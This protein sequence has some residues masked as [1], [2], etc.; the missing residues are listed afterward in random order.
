[1]RLSLKN[2]VILKK[3]ISLALL[4]S[5]TFTN[6]AAV[7]AFASDT[8]ETP[9]YSTPTTR[10]TTDLTQLGRQGRLRENLNFENETNRL[11]KV[12]AGSGIR[13]P[14]LLDERNENQ[15]FIVEQLAIRMANGTVTENLSGKKIL[16]LENSD[17]FSN[18]KSVAEVSSN[19]TAIL[20]DA[21]AS[22]G[23]IILFVDQLS[24]FTGNG[25]KLT[26]ALAQG[27]LKIIGGSSKAAYREKVEK[28]AEVAA[29][30]ETICVK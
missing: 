19:V 20:D 26:T 28:F 17:L 23:Q 9:A 27:K 14:V 6:L 2:I 5:F 30:F 7:R 1:M 12:L 25:N 11:I 21:I 18:A 24:N 29:L 3:A 15:D 13:Q 22:N 4:Y 8:N 10:F 16:K